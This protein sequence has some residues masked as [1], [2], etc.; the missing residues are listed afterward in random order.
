M[1]GFEDAGSS[2]YVRPVPTRPRRR[3]DILIRPA[4]TADL[5]HLCAIEQAVFDHEQLT[6]RAFRRY[7][8]L[9]GAECLVACAQAGPVGYAI[10]SYRS[11]STIARLISIAVATRATGRGIGMALLTSAGERAK[12]RGALSMRLEVRRDNLAGLSLYRR[13]GYTVAG[14]RPGYYDDF[15]DAILLQRSLAA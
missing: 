3:P 14:V 1:G 4:G 8:G 5:D 11:G 15:C 7:A 13:A 6:R 2:A 12:A 9:A 10:V